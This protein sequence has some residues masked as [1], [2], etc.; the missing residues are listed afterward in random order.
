MTKLF[1]YSLFFQHVPK[2]WKVA[3][4]KVLK[5]KDID[6]D[7]P[8]SYRP[9]SLL[10]TTSRIL[11]RIMNQ[12]ITK[13]VDSI[14]LINPCQ[15]GFRK[16]HSCQ[17]NIFKI[18]ET[19]KIGL[20]NGQKCGKTDFDVEKAFDKAPHKGILMTLKSFKCPNYIGNWLVSFF[21]DRKFVV[22]IEGIFSD[23]KN[24]LA[25][26]PQGSPLSPLLFSL[27]I[28]EI[29]KILERHDIYFALFAD[30]LTIWKI[31]K[32]LFTIQAILQSAF[33]EINTFFIQKGLK[34][35]ESKCIYTIFTIKLKDRIHLMINNVPIDYCQN[36]KTLGI[37]FDPKLKFNY[38]FIELR[39]Q[40]TSKINLLRILNNKSNRLN[41]AHIL[42][43][44]KSLILSK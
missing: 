11:E 37:F 26:V 20:Q 5:K 2:C 10:V 17:D 6:L 13:W 35:N 19:C 8:S 33:D 43:I 32:D 14:K 23:E 15:S 34:L 1:N 38:H 21:S 24:I 36:P 4:I 28:N 30:D 12:R 44:Y 9:I 18:I 39:K 41:I 42:K 40:L 31:H 22:E 27:F 29:G 3:K 7:N 25:G 16:N